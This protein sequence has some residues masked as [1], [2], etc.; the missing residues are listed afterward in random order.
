VSESI[1]CENGWR[2]LEATD[3]PDITLFGVLSGISSDLAKS[4]VSIFA[5]ST[6][7]TDYIFI[8]QDRFEAGI[9]ALEACGIRIIRS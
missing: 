4:E 3:S 2:C 6:H 8:R 7:D 5:V 1:R 9:A